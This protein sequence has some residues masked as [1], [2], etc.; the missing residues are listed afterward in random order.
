MGGKIGTGAKGKERRG[1]S[2]ESFYKTPAKS[3]KIIQIMV[4]TLWMTCR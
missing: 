1:M 2:P 4:D 3:P